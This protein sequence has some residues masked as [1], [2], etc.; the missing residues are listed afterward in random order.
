MFFCTNKKKPTDPT[1]HPIYENG[2]GIIGPAGG[3]IR[4]SDA[5]SNIYGAYVIIP[6]GAISDDINIKISKAEKNVIYLEDTNAVIIKFE[7]AG[8]IFD[9]PLEI[10]LPYNNVNNHNLLQAFYFNPDSNLLEQLP[11]KSINTSQKTVVAFTNHFSHFLVN[12]D[13]TVAT[14]EMYYNSNKIGV[15]VSLDGYSFGHNLGLAG[16]PTL[17]I[18]WP[19]GIFNAKQAINQGAFLLAGSQPHAVFK[20]ILKEK[21]DYWADKTLETKTLV[22][23][24][25]GSPIELTIG[26]T[27]YVNEFDN[28]KE[29]ISIEDQNSD[30]REKWFSGDAL[31]FNFDYQTQ[32]NKEY[33][34]K[35]KWAITGSFG[36]SILYG[37][38]TKVYSFNSYNSCLSTSDMLTENLDDNNNYVIDSYEPITNTTPTATF[39][40]SPPSGTVETVFQFDASGSSDA[41]DP[42]SALQVRWDWE[43]D[44]WDTNYSTDKTASH[45]YNTQGTKTI[46]FEVKD[47]GGLSNSTTRQI[48]VAQPLVLDRIEITPSSITLH[49]G[50][51]QQ[52]T[53]IAY[54]SNGDSAD[55]T[56]QASWTTSPGIAGSITSTGFFTAHSTNIGDELITVSFNGKENRANVKIISPNTPPIASFTVSPSSGPVENI[57]QF[58][59]SGCIDNKDQTSVLQVRWDWEND[60]YW[61][62]N[63]STT[64]TATHQY[65]TF[66]IK[67]AKLEVKDTDGLTDTTS[68]QITVTSQNT[69]PTASFTVSPTLGTLDTVFQFDASGCA[70]N[71]DQTSALQVRWDWENDGL[72]DTDYTTTKTETHQYSTEGTKTIALEVRDTGSLT[73]KISRQVLIDDGGGDHETGTMTGNNGRIYKT[74]KIGNQWWM[75]ENLRETH[76]CN[77]DTIPEVTDDSLWSHSWSVGGRCSYENDENNADIYGYLYNWDAI[78]YPGRDITPPDWHLPT[79]EDWQTLVDY[80]G[81]DS[82]AGG[83]LKET[84]TAHWN[85]PNIG[86]TN[87][88]GFTALPAGYREHDGSFKYL[89][90][91][92]FFWSACE[93]RY[94]DDFYKAWSR[95]LYFNYSDV[96]R[97]SRG[98]RYLGGFSIRLVRDY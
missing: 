20:V 90:S 28:W 59:A 9:K 86:A 71:E 40:V 75:A 70:D 29:L 3:T 62:T 17:A 49:N 55:V 66:G 53:C 82:L 68:T 30:E 97:H 7:P 21:L 1:E 35:F 19:F 56:N 15:N 89:G 85:S 39:T 43:N 41:E 79:H 31:F 58:D 57:F 54:Y 93:S 61:D 12:D 14:V 2:E 38:A 36:F 27:L 10:G 5:S 32:N 60:G 37:H 4:V 46:K 72:W 80:L 47:T 74:V 67:T 64:K 91:R 96:I 84:G 73:D 77:G 78:F 52:F 48:E 16:I 18:S 25:T 83:K 33:Y 45:K 92:A 63:Y 76:Y 11:I 44:G 98:Y 88:S 8:F 23:K 13:G 26:G 51:T 69:S 42:T 22:Y 65:S 50:Q 81:G 6:D 34:V 95:I 24:R 87:R 94:S